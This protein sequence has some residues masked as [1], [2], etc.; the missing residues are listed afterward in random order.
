MQVTLYERAG[1]S[2]VG[3]SHVQHGAEQWLEMVQTL[4]DDGSGNAG[5]DG[6]PC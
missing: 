4:R 6:S 5:G 3:P 2:L 1:F